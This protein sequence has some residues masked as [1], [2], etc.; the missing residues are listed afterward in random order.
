MKI[1]FDPAKRAAT[2]QLRSLDFADASLVFAGLT[3]DVADSRQ[4]YGEP[5][6]Q[7]IGYLAGR[8]VMVVWTP[9][10]DARRIMSM[11]YCN[12]RERKIYGP[13]LQIPQ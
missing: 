8:M 12:D 4:D 13:H 6:V 3:M 9:R 2:L 5:R 10:G 11:R 1:T 7:T